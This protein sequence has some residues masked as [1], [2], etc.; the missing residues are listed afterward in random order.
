M[1][2]KTMIGK[3][4]M[5]SA[6]VALVLSLSLSGC[7]TPGKSWFKTD[8]EQALIYW[9]TGDYENAVEYAK[10]ALRGNEKDPYALMV[11]A[12]SY[13]SLGYPNL[14]RRY[15]EDLLLSDSD[16]V[17]VFPAVKNMPA[18]ELRKGAIERL[19][20]MEMKKSPF[21]EVR[22]ESKTV[23]FTDDAFAKTDTTVQ[24][25]GGS[26]VLQK[27]DIKGGLD[28]LTEGD[29]NVVERFLTVTRL[30]DEKYIT[31]DEWERRRTVN[32]GGL[33]PYTLEPA[34]QGLDLPAPEGDVIIGRLDALRHALEMRAITP[35]E[36]AA[37]RE[38]ILEALLPSNPFYRMTP[39]P[40]PQDILEGANA[41]RRIQMLKRLG[42]ITPEEAKAETAAIEKLTYA[43]IGMT[44]GGQPNNGAAQCIRKCLAA[45]V[46]TCKPAP[47]PVPVKKKVKPK[48][49]P[50]K[51]AA[52]CTCAS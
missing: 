9:S 43:K 20:M 36:H 21:A 15:Y 24:T 49:K 17:G 44:D 7:S 6:A 2:E 51:P 18:E 13:D 38:I 3:N 28:M 47:A 16:A 1:G 31:R 40:P 22:P 35:R 41:L 27:S 14:S 23:A 29:R 30:R 42:L 25:K 12:F 52:A 33:L 10:S 8:T 46:P 39:T 5:K 45:P 11:A 37:E 50:A 4:L 19:K 26:V 32:L 34:G 48:K